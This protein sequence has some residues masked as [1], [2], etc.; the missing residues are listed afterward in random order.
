MHT[1]ESLLAALH[2]AAA[3]GD[4]EATAFLSMFA[5]WVTGQEAAGAAP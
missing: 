4:V 3:K 2:H 5:K 1:P